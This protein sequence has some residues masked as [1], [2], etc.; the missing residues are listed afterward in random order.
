MKLWLLTVILT[1]NGLHQEWFFDETACIEEMLLH[2]IVTK[3][4][5]W[6]AKCV[7]PDGQEVG[8]TETRDI[9]P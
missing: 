6:S 2:E 9:G 5:L 4:S 3:K 1:T 8:S 7:G